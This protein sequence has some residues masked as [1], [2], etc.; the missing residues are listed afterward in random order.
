MRPAG[1]RIPTIIDAIVTGIR[2][3]AAP[4]QVIDGPA[5]ADHIEDD[6]ILIALTPGGSEAVTVTTG[7]NGLGG[8]P[9]DRFTLWCVISCFRGDPAVSPV[10]AR[11]GDL[12]DLVEEWL[13]DNSTIDQV[14][15]DLTLG[16]DVTWTPAQFQGGVAVEVSFA[17][18]GRCLR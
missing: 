4:V 5:G 17:I 14:A 7:T 18:T 8:R 10:R 6:A 13:Q 11:A 16:P 3:H 2:A 15:D 9:S 12:L 1:T